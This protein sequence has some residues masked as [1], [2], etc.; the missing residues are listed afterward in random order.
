MAPW[1]MSLI[2]SCQK[3]QLQITKSLMKVL[4]TQYLFLEIVFIKLFGHD[5]VLNPELPPGI[6]GIHPILERDVFIELPNRSFTISIKQIPIILSFTLTIDK[7]QGL[8]FLGAIF[9]PL[10]NLSQRN[11]NKNHTLYVVLSRMKHL[12]YLQVLEPLSHSVL[13]YFQPINV[14]LAKDTR[15]QA[16]EHIA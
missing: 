13:K 11:P 16:L 9:R 5:Q 3:L 10:F 1:V 15:L 6:I 12:I 14:H 2:T 7:C 8:T 4:G